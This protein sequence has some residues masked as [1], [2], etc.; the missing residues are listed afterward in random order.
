M[1]SYLVRS[2]WCTYGI[3]FSVLCGPGT[4]N[5]EGPPLTKP[6]WTTDAT[7]EIYHN[8]SIHLSI[9]L[10]LTTLVHWPSHE[11]TGQLPLALLPHPKAAHIALWFGP[12]IAHMTFWKGALLHRVL[13]TSWGWFSLWQIWQENKHHVQVLF[14]AELQ[15]HISIRMSGP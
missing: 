11:F 3:T 5:S 13:K 9:H 8:L 2:K 10:F 12:L 1:Q 6:I 14:M 7:W 15:L 4:T